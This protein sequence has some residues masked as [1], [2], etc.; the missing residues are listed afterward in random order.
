MVISNCH[1]TGGLLFASRRGSGSL[2][3]LGKSTIASDFIRGR[4]IHGRILDSIEQLISFLPPGRQRLVC[5]EFCRRLAFGR[6][7]RLAGIDVGADL[8]HVHCTLRG[9]HHVTGSCRVDLRLSWAFHYFVD[10]GFG[11]LTA[12]VS[13]I[14]NM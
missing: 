13:L 11:L 9:L 4:V 6:V 1:S 14:R 5:V 2:S 12:S 10:K 7:T 3:H 8:K